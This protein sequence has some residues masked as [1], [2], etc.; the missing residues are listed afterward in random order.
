MLSAPG[1][2]IVFDNFR[3]TIGSI[4]YH[5]PW[6]LFSGIFRPFIWEAQNVMQFL[7]S[8]ENMA[9]FLLF[10]SSFKNWKTAFSSTNRLLILSLIVYVVLLCIF[11]TL[12]APNYGTLSRYRV[13]FLPFFVLL[14]SI[15]N[16]V[17]YYLYNFAQRFLSR[18]AR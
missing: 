6:A 3:P 12:S 7:S 4:L 13:G 15:N 10:I 1:D 8:I 16:P 14:L 9:V 17:V 11:L 5:S 2:A 18:I